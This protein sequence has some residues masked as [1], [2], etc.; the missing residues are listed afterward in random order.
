M[1]KKTIMKKLP[2]VDNSTPK[3]G[4]KP[5]LKEETKK[6]SKEK[7]A[8]IKNTAPENVSQSD[9]LKQQKEILSNA[10]QNLEDVEK[11]QEKLNVIRVKYRTK[12]MEAEHVRKMARERIDK[13]LDIISDLKSELIK[14]APDNILLEI[15]SRITEITNENNIGRKRAL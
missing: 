12:Y 15:Q 8:E 14:Y 4:R 1:P 2:S 3:R 10:L 11:L 13:L 9:F 6:L 7:I 5:K